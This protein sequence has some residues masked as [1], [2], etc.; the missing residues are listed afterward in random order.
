MKLIRVLILQHISTSVRL[1][2]SAM[3]LW[4]N[5]I[6]YLL[7][8]VELHW[9]KT[10]PN[11][12]SS[13]WY[14]ITFVL[15]T[16]SWFTEHVRHLMTATSDKLPVRMNI[17]DL[18][19]H[20]QY[21]SPPQILYFSMKLHLPTIILKSTEA[22]CRKTED[23]GVNQAFISHTWMFKQTLLKSIMFFSLCS[24]FV[25]FMASQDMQKKNS[26]IVRWTCFWEL[27]HRKA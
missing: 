12:M 21:T 14:H 9:L 23:A 13:T 22:K 26:I 18:T 11:G 24:V 10:R 4:S 25:V 1:I 27:G 19:L 6:I 7:K 2:I 17:T 8:P 15:N 5:T 3:L 20:I 16:C